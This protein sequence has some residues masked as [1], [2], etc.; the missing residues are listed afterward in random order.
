MKI[1][2]AHYCEGAGHATKM[3]AIASQLE[4]NKEVVVAGGGPGKKFVEINGH[5]EFEPQRVR[6]VENIQES[7]L[8]PPIGELAANSLKRISDYRKWLGNEDPD[9]LITDDIF[10]AIAAT[11]SGKDYYCVKH[12]TPDFYDSYTEKAGC[13]LINFFMKKTSQEFFRPLIWGEETEGMTEVGPLGLENN[14]EVEEVD[15]LLVPST[16]SGDEIKNVLGETE[17]DV[18]VVGAPE[19]SPKTSLQPYIESA[20]TVVCSGY[21]TVMEAAL[22]GTSCVM[23]PETSEQRGVAN[24]ISSIKGFEKASKENLERKLGEVGEPEKMENG[25]REIVQKILDEPG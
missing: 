24:R 21:S 23:V 12:D 15:I 7:G 13:W 22:A 17:R 18:K 4:E 19:W 10:A 25:A 11:I 16:Y 6:F 3:L 5:K 9:L 14:S 2:L 20:D 8:F 1:G